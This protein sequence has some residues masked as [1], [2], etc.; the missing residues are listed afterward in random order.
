VD[1]EDEDLYGRVSNSRAL[2]DPKS[3][4]PQD[5]LLI[6]DDGDLLSFLPRDLRIDEEI[7]QLLTPLEPPGAEAIPRSP[8]PHHQRRQDLLPVDKCSIWSGFRGVCHRSRQ[9]RSLYLDSP[10]GMDEL[11]RYPQFLMQYRL[12]F[13]FP[14][15]DVEKAPR[16]PSPLML[17][18]SHRRP[19]PRGPP[20]FPLLP[21][22][23]K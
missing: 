5:P 2:I 6:R 10:V 15:P 7:L 19:P 21:H 8:T 9:D 12:F 11:T 18:K 20:A 1:S 13:P 14:P 17:R 4:N 16:P 22:G 23:Q 3:G